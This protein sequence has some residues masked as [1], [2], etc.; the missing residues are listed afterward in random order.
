MPEKRDGLYIF[1]GLTQKEI[2]YFVM[3]SEVKKFASGTKI[4][5]EGNATDNRA[6]LIESG[7]VD[8]YRQKVKIDSLHTGDIFGEMALITD[9]PRSAT[10]IA[11][12]PVEVLIFNKNE[13]LI[14]CKKSGLYDDIKWKILRRVKENFYENN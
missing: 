1:E 4:I 11:N 8:V 5:S 3:M 7:S 12:S 2:S 6:Y 10:V 13:F 9:E 14:L